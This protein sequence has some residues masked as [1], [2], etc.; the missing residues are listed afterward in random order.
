MESSHANSDASSPQPQSLKEEASEN[1]DTPAVSRQ[2]THQSL[3]G[4]KRTA[5]GKTYK[6][7]STTAVKRAGKSER[8][9]RAKFENLK[10]EQSEVV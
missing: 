10:L 8:K 7:S 5:S 6:S 9:Q 2:K 3:A 4:K 1:S